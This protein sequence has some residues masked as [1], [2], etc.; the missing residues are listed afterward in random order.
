MNSLEQR[1]KEGR[2]KLKGLK[3]H[4]DEIDAKAVA[5][6][7]IKDAS[8]LSGGTTTLDFDNVEKQ[9]RDLSTK[10]DVELAFHDEKGKQASASDVGSL[11]TIIKQTSTAGNTV[12]EIDKILGKK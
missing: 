3:M 10:I 2:D 8:A 6:K 9:V 12:S 4:L 7:S 11:D 5:L 1:E